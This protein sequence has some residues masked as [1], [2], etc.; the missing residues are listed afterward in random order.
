MGQAAARR[1]LGRVQL[2]PGRVSPFE[3]R[4]DIEFNEREPITPLGSFVL[5]WAGMRGVV[6]V[7]AAQ[8]IPASTAH[9]ATVVLAAFLVAL[10]TLV[11]F[12]LSLPVVIRRCDFHSESPE[13][14]RDSVRALL[15]RVGESAIDTLGPL[16][17]QTVDGD[18]VDPELAERM[19]DRVLPRVIAGVQQ[20]TGARPDSFEKAMILQRRYLDAMRDA[21]ASERGIGA[22]SSQTYR[23][24]E[25]LLDSMEQRVGTT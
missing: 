18:P 24:V 4:A 22:Y 17:E 11:L 6:T 21:L 8:T 16:E 23:Q 20:T 5:A 3:S 10:I 1:G 7:A 19:R 2:Y 14:R 12:G 9:R 15:K 25:S 13:E